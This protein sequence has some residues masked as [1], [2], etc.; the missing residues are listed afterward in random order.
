MKIAVPQ[1]CRMEPLSSRREEK[2][3]STSKGTST[4]YAVRRLGVEAVGGDAPRKHAVG[5][6]G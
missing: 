5:E 2:T 3:C 4:G 1:H 6:S